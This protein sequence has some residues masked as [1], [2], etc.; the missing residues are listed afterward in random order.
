MKPIG[1]ILKEARS[2]NKLT[3][4]E[5]ED[6]T[7][8]S[9]AYLSQL[10]NDKIKNASATI[11]YK[12]C[13]LYGIDLTYLMEGLLILKSTK[14]YPELSDAEKDEIINF[15]KFRFNRNG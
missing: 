15:L 4:R 12:L 8:I 13:K 10:E 14:I 9:N 2:L 1:S 7:K 3:L 5:V 11:L 6:F